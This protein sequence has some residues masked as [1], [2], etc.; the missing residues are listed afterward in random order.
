VRP[1]KQNR[2]Y[3]NEVSIREMGYDSFEN[4]IYHG[5]VAD[6]KDWIEFGNINVKERRDSEGNTPLHHACNGFKE[7]SNAMKDIVDNDL[8][9]VKI[10]IDAGC[11]VN[12]RNN[13]G[14]TPLH[15]ALI[16]EFDNRIEMVKL[17]VENGA[18]V[19]ARDNEEETPLHIEHYGDPHTDIVEYLISKGADINAK[20]KYGKRPICER[21]NDDYECECG[22]ATAVGPYCRGCYH[23]IYGY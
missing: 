5:D 20:N 21:S 6:V 15:V 12:A 9:L 7:N 22:R 17:L 23:D 10:F 1:V 4:V 8:D 3:T 2:T 18:D 16:C 13:Q 19:N 14:Q 11:D